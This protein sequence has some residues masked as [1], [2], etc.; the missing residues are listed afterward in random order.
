MFLDT[1]PSEPN[2]A[3]QMETQHIPAYTAHDGQGNLYARV[4]PTQFP[5]ATKG[6]APLIH[7]VTAY[8]RA[9]LWD[10]VQAW[11]AGGAVAKGTINPDASAVHTFKSQGGATWRIYSDNTKREERMPVA[12]S[13]FATPKALDDTTYGYTWDKDTVT[14]EATVR[15]LPQYYRLT[16]NA[17]DKDEWVVVQAAEVPKETGLAEVEFPQRRTVKPEPYTT[18]DAAKSS[19]KTPGPAAGPFEAKLGD[20]SVVTYS[21]YR[22]ADQPALQNAD[23]T[24][25]EREAMQKR[26]ELLHKEW[27][28]DRDYLPPP[29]VGTLAELDPGVLVTPPQ[30]LEIGY[31][32]IVTRQAKQP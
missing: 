14:T 23:M 3:I 1:R 27:T 15:T 22:F 4:A 25:D 9:A 17:K 10:D 13:S 18:P 30:G 8:K 21:W 5:L 28:S 26:V 20:G 2:K 29:K 31:V 11:F 12:W 7:Q 32:P 24:K 19:W 6:D 16:K